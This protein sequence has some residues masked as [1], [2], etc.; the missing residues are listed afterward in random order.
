MRVRGGTSPSLQHSK[1]VNRE[2]VIKTKLVDSCVL[3]DSVTMSL[4]QFTGTPTIEQ[5][6]KVP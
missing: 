6:L 4:A 1:M 2:S 5:R 3:H